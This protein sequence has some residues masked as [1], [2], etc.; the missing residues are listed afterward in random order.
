M[1]VQGVPAGRFWGGSELRHLQNASSLFRFSAGEG[2]GFGKA[3]R[4]GCSPVPTVLQ[5]AVGQQG[6]V[7]QQ[8]QAMLRIPPCSVHPEASLGS[9]AFLPPAMQ[10]L[11][12]S[13]KTA[14]TSGSSFEI[15]IEG[16]GGKN[17]T[18]LFLLAFVRN[19]GCFKLLASISKK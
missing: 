12:A 6:R 17:K 2:E 5:G 7:G 1:I 4:F 10:L 18:D 9:G 16:K 3:R 19:P 15:Q 13:A 8:V 11:S 14:S